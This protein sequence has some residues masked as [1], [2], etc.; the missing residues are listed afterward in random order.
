MNDDEV[1]ENAN[2]NIANLLAQLDFT[3]LSVV[4]KAEDECRRAWLH[5]GE[6]GSEEVYKYFFGEIL[7][8]LLEFSM[9]RLRKPLK[10][11]ALLNINIISKIIQSVLLKD[12]RMEL[13]EDR[14]FIA[15]KIK[16]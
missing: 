10:I 15:D 14:F 16:N 13:R 9:L 12:Y 6:C 7:D 3:F 8:V 5:V 11:L 1:A 4:N 2:K